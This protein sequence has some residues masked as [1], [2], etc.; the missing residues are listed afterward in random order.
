[1]P[2]AKTITGV[3]FEYSGSL[4][5]GLVV[6]KGTGVMISTEI[7]R[8]IRDEIKRRSP[9]LMGACRDN[10]AKHSLGETLATIPGASP[11]YLSY[12]VPLL[13]EEGYCTVNDRRPIIISRRS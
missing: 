1:M 6:H 9:V 2:R 7:I 11:Q 4:D 13:V 10:P 5:S 12:V 8:F 3:E